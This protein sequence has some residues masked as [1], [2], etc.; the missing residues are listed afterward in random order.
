MR[1]WR[2]KEECRASLESDIPLSLGIT[3]GGFLYLP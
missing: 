1:E 3:A 2:V